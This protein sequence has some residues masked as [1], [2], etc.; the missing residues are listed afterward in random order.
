MKYVTQTDGVYIDVNEDGNR[1]KLD[2]AVAIL[3]ANGDLTMKVG[4]AAIIAE[5]PIVATTA[6]DMSNP[7]T[8]RLAVAAG[9][10]TQGEANRIGRVAA[11]STPKNDG[12][13]IA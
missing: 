10:I 12:S 9:L 5:A 3:E 8:R 13:G 11:T 6:Y 4:P 2:G 7:D 1:I